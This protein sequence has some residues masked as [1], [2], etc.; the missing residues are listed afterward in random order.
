MNFRTL[1]F[2]ALFL[3]FGIF[4][5]Y[6]YSV[7]AI[8]L[9]YVLLLL[10]V[11]A[12]VCM[13]TFT[14]AQWRRVCVS[15]ALLLLSFTL[16]AVCFS[17]QLR[18]FANSEVYQGDYALVGRVVDKQ[19]DET[20]C[21]LTLDRVHVEGEELEGKTVAYL[22]REYFEV[23]SLSDEVLIEGDLQTQ[24]TLFGEYGFRAYAIEED[25]R[26]RVQV[27][28]C[29][30]VSS[31]FHL[32]LSIRQRM[33]EVTYAGMDET[34]AAVTMATLTGNT[35]GIEEGLLN[36]IRRGG[37]AH[38]FA[39]SG[40]HIGALYA[41]CLWIIARTKLRYTPKFVRFCILLVVLLLYGGICGYSASVVRAIVMCLLLYISKQT[42]LGSDALENISA[43]AIFVLLLSPVSLFTV[44]F[45][46]S[47]AACYGIALF[48]RPLERG[49]YRMGAWVKYSL[50]RR[51]RKPFVLEEDT[52]PLNNVQRLTRATVSFLSVTL[53][54]QIATTPIQ[55][56]AFSYLSVYSLL[57]NCLF[58]PVIS[59]AFS[60][61]L[62]FTFLACILPMKWS[63]VVLYIPN[64]VWSGLLLPFEVYSFG[65][66]EIASVPFAAT[67]S[68][69][70][71]A[72]LC[73]GRWNV[74]KK[75]L[76]LFAA[77]F[78]IACVC[79]FVLANA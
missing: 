61:L 15:V 24:T 74:K 2:C 66:V 14:L 65:A 33:E 58:V 44:G 52:H 42:G 63:F 30:V 37:I 45:Q 62:A 4:F 54:A 10:P 20:N 70:T 48:A 23:V 46:L 5:G 75:M 77:A 36:N 49:I 28:T 21:V 35:T 71:T 19:A 1:L 73:C 51:E 6:L 16:G 34:P 22:P 59:C 68:Y 79:S 8:S 17:T 69:Y 60:L 13:L 64:V 53:A 11:I 47:F 7:Y 25:T 3:C 18:S 78:A 55:I 27:D 40:L 67:A 9:W 72:A 76:L 41:V 26:Y 57:L 43:A 31:D 32:F 38:I 56:A 50:L 39:V 12:V 29:T